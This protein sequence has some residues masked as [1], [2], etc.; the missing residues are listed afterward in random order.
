MTVKE[1]GAVGL[2]GLMMGG[3][4]SRIGFTSW[5]EIHHMF[6][7]RDLRLVL[8][9]ALAVVVLAVSWAVIRKLSRPKWTSRVFHK[10]TIPGGILFGVGWAVSGACPSIAMVSLGEG[11][12]AA[13]VTL[14]GVFVGNWLY[15]VAQQRWL[16]WSTHS[17]IDD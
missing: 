10:G 14:G 7:F 13:I 8:V 4:L 17:C 16:H 11:Q 15:G 12:L 5:D 1:Y 9:F 2:V 3:A 6:T